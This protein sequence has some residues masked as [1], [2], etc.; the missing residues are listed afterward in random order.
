MQRR[1]MHTG[2]LGTAAIAF[3]GVVLLLYV[4]P[5]I[6][7]EISVGFGAGGLR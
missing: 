3:T 2:S 1:Y 7:R 5:L 6:L 4:P